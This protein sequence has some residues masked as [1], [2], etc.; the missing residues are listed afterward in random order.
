MPRGDGDG[1]LWSD[2]LTTL[3][4]EAGHDT[5][6][7][8]QAHP[9]TPR[10][11]TTHVASIRKKEETASYQIDCSHPL[12]KHPNTPQQGGGSLQP[13]RSHRKAENKDTD[14]AS[15]TTTTTP[16]QSGCV[17]DPLDMSGLRQEV[18]VGCRR[19]ERGSQQTEQ[20]RTD[21]RFDLHDFDHFSD[22]RRWHHSHL[23]WVGLSA[24]SGVCRGGYLTTRSLKS[25]GFTWIL[26]LASL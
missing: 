12:P 18:K 3:S 21:F 13:Q 19:F 8:S 14:K 9:C 11:H 1:E 15:C 22:V 26:F 23:R 17:S 16:V 6:R 20:N 24:W 4:K 2:T 25:V 10:R 7:C 5:P